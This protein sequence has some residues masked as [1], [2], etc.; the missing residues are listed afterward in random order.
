M[1]N[2]CHSLTQRDEVLK[3][4]HTLEYGSHFEN[5]CDDNDRNHE[6]ARCSGGTL[7]ALFNITGTEK[8]V[9]NVQTS[10]HS[11]ENECHR[12]SCIKNMLLRRLHRCNTQNG[13][14]A[15][16]SFEN[17]HFMKKKIVRK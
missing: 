17:F 12:N 5:Y 1:E 15:A 8:Y 3:A 2:F 13:K 9:Q 6:T 10:K 14:I 16:N 11:D 7:H 4:V